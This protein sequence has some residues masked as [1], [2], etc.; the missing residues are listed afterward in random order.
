MAT[1]ASLAA[2]VLTAECIDIA[3]A[4]D[5]SQQ[6]QKFPPIIG[7]LQCLRPRTNTQWV[8]SPEAGRGI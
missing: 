3:S 4:R 8:I 2:Q 7:P 1:V 5:S 6:K